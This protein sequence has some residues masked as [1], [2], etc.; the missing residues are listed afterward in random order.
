M[1]GKVSLPELIKRLREAAG[2]ADRALLEEKS[3]TAS[4]GRPDWFN[5]DRIA[6]TF[7][8]RP[9]LDVGEQP[10]GTVMSQLKQ[11]AAG[12][13][14]ELITPF[15]PAPLVDMAK[16]RGFNTWTTTME[17]GVVKTYFC[18]TEER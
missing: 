3:K 1:V 10:M 15:E 6:Q 17:P 18:K 14:F 7:D 8:A 5:P 2:L 4:Y 16:S 12:Q 9:L 13:V 11:L